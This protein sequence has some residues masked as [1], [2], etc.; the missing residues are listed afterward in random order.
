M[1]S[2]IVSK[3]SDADADAQPDPLGHSMLFT[4]F[5][6]FIDH[7]MAR[8]EDETV[9]NLKQFLNFS[10]PDNDPRKSQ[11][12]NDFEIPLVRS[13]GRIMQDTEEPIPNR[14]PLNFETPFLDL[15]IVYGYDA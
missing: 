10:L 12:P 7:D 8:T 15:S 1:I 14:V 3:I 4:M 13:K 9:E 6:Q 11:L 2:N 5:G